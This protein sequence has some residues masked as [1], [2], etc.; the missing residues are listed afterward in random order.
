MCFGDPEV[1]AP[2]EEVVTVCIAL[3]GGGPCAEGRTSPT[4]DGA[5]NPPPPDGSP[6]TVFV[7]AGTYDEQ[8]VF[9]SANP[10]TLVGEPGARI[11]N[12]DLVLELVNAADVTVSGLELAGGGADIVRVRDGA[13]LRLDSCRIGPSDGNGVDADSSSDVAITRTRIEQNSDGGVKLRGRARVENCVFSANGN[14]SSGSNG[15]AS[16]AATLDGAPADVVFRFNTLRDNVAEGPGAVLCAQAITVESIISFNNSTGSG[17]EFGG[18][19]SVANSRVDN[20]GALGAGAGN[21]DAD[22]LFDV[23]GVHLLA[24]SP[25]RGVGNPLAPLDD[26]DGDVRDAQPDAGADEIP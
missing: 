4:I 22:P 5:V 17:G 7:T 19:C 1:C 16:G 10:I 8:V 23:D 13:R 15:S 26:L 9:G 25:C 2:A 6:V 20:P 18:L 21:F 24:T 12:T 14:D 3:V 11:T